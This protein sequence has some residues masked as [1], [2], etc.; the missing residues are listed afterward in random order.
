MHLSVVIPVFNARDSLRSCLEHLFRSDIDDYECIV[1]DDGS[2]DGSADVAR[3]FRVT[4]VSTGFRGG[5][6]RARNLG[7][8]AAKGEILLF[9][10]ADVWVEPDTL[11]RVSDFFAANP[12]VSA[13]F[14]SYD[15]EPYH[16]NFLSQYKNLAHAFVHRTAHA[17][18]STFWTGCGAVRRGVFVGVGGF[19]ERRDRPA[20]E[21]IELG[22]RL[23]LAGHRIR[24]DGTLRVKHLKLWSFWNLVRTDIFERSVPWTDMTIRHRFMPDDLN[25][26]GGQRI[27]VVLALALPATLLASALPGS[28]LAPAMIVSA[29]MLA[30][31]TALNLP[32]L[33][34]LARRRGRLFALKAAPLNLLAHLYSG[35]TFGVCLLTYPVRRSVANYPKRDA[36]TG[37][38]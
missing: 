15:D 24:L 37:P 30:A 13:V 22:Y 2:T 21:D 11:R 25:L 3:E 31:H 33:R 9:V 16:P 36:Q 18:A 38:L 14:G 32:L 12:D 34:F 19:D 29:G 27:S 26:E 17:E 4:V 6:A 8:R 10:D 1:V 5:P 23:K 28:P 20:C 7:V 35:L